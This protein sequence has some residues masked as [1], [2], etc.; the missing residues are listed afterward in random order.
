MA[1]YLYVGNLQ[2][3]KNGNYR[4]SLHN[5]TSRREI[6]FTAGVP[7]EVTDE[8]EMAQIEFSTCRWTKEFE[9]VRVS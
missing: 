3:T 8:A 7:F 4:V 1:M 9:Y 2:P 6:T 5:G